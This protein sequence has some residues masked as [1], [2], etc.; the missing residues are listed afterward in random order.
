MVRL[1]SAIFISSSRTITPAHM[2]PEIGFF[3]QIRGEK[4]YHVYDPSAVNEC[5]LEN[6][7]KLN[8]V[9]ICQVDLLKLDATKEHVFHLREG[10]GFHQPQNAPHWV[11]TGS[12]QSVSYTF[13]FETERSR[14]RG[15]ARAFNYYQR[16]L[17]LEPG[18]PGARPKLDKLKSE[19]MKGCFPIKSA[20]GKT[21]NAAHLR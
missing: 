13:V 3:C 12:E 5:E 19:A 2:D 14:T 17:G 11:E 21:L 18:L 4:F 15:R 16:R 9:R 6:F 20:I 7:Y 1:E 10:N 8:D